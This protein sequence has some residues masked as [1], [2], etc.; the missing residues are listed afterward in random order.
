M[1]NDRKLM[2]VEWHDNF[3]QSG[4]RDVEERVTEE[5]MRPVRIQSV[6]WVLAETEEVLKLAASIGGGDSCAEVVGIMK[7]CIVRQ[8]EITF[9]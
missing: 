4:W 2:L 9:E 7:V 3:S 8:E 5:N 6:G 1:K